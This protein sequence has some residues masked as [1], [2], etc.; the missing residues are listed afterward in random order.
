[1]LIG[2]IAWPVAWRL[3]AVGLLA[4]CA[5][6]FINWAIY[7]WA[8]HYRGLGPWNAPPT[9]ERQAKRP[10]GSKKTKQSGFAPR[11]WLDHLPV[12]GW[13]RLRSEGVVY[14]RWY[15]LRPLLIELIFPV[16]IAWYYHFYVSGQA[17]QAGTALRGL[18]PELYSQCFAHCVLF[19]L[20]TIATFIDFDEQSIPDYVTLPGTVIGL[21]GAALA[22][23]WLPFDVSGPTAREMHAAIP[24]EWPSWLNGPWGLLFGLLIIGI[25]GFALLERR[26]I[27]RRGF[28]KGL[29]Y[30]W[31]HVSK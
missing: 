31:A 20:M 28:A 2:F 30:F 3:L 22:P 11:S 21:A 7:S 6:R 26:F 9:P 27:W 17:L 5:A 14:G 10:S 12:W 19:S 13:Y 18:S 16:A 24:D 29:R 8:Y 23:A 25:W 15:W 1:M 4:V